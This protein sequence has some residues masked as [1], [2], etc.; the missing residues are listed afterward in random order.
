[1]ARSGAYRPRR[2]H[3]T[4]IQEPCRAGLQPHPADRRGVRRPR[5]AAVAVPQAGR[6]PA[7]Q[8][9]ARI[10][11]RRRALRPL[12]VHRP[13]GAHAAARDRHGAPRCVHRR[14]GRRD[15]RGQ[16]ARLHRAPTSS[17]SRSRCGPGCRAS[18]AGW[19][20]TSATTRCAT[21][22]PS[23]RRRAE[24]RRPRH[25]RHPAAADR[26]AGGHRQPVGPAVPDR[27]CRPGAARGVLRAPSGGSPN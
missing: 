19:P 8:L 16:P 3:R 25:A 26:G 5:H 2:D 10:G 21:S 18:A 7:A 24:A 22:R 14:R 9:P 1:M 17:A 4:R 20:A 13:A 11:G 27:L 23:W 15:A 12:L 6:R